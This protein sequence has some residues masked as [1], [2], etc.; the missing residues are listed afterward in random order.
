MLLLC[1]DIYKNDYMQ[2]TDDAQWHFHHIIGKNGLTILFSYYSYIFILIRLPFQLTS[3]SSV[4]HELFCFI[5]FNGRLSSPKKTP[6]FL[7][8]W[9]PPAEL[10]K[11]WHLSASSV[12]V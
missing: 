7:F 1:R 10:F 4:V 8:S 6:L 11:L 3:V 5:H 12:T 9:Y 2:T